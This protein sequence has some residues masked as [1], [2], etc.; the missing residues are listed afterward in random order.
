MINNNE[1]RF[2]RRVV[3]KGWI[4]GEKILE[5]IDEIRSAALA[6]DKTLMDLLVEKGYLSRKKIR[7][8]QQELEQTDGIKAS[9]ESAPDGRPV[10][11]YRITQKIGEGAM[12]VVYQATNSSNNRIVALKLL[13]KELSEDPEFIARFLREARNAAKLKKHENIVEAYDFGQADGRYYFA[14]EFVNG[15]SLAEILFCQGL[16]SER[17]ALSI[18]RQLTRALS[19]ANNFSIIHRDIKPE[20]IIISQDGIVKLCDL[21]LAKDLS[22][23]FFQAKRRHH[24]GNCV[25]CISRAGQWLQRPG[26]PRR[27]LFPGDYLILY[28]DRRTSF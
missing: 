28:A 21:G 24:P 17:T 16:L 23:D 20:N 13:D 25:L 15:R 3:Y 11:R 19:H 12:G 6:Q 5:C 8:V 22:R 26:H 27:Y 4:S 10:G 9:G 7:Q 2:A 14:M 18:T 1:L